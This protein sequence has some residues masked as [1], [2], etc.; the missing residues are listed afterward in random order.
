MKSRRRWFLRH[1]DPIQRL[2]SEDGLCTRPFISPL[3]PKNCLSSVYNVFFDMWWSHWYTIFKISLWQTRNKALQGTVPPKLL[4]LEQMTSKDQLPAFLF[5]FNLLFL[6]LWGWLKIKQCV[7]NKSILSSNRRQPECV[8]KDTSNLSNVCFPKTD[9]LLLL[10]NTRNPRDFFFFIYAWDLF[11][12]ILGIL[13]QVLKDSLM[14]D[15]SYTP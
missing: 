11:W 14:P 6:N 2:F 5:I 9:S 4:S 12:W 7:M 13:V 15:Q 10:L 3:L 1:V 8:F